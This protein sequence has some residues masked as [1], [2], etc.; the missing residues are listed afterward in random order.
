GVSGPALS[1]R[2]RRRSADGTRRGR[3]AGAASA[4]R[5]RAWGARGTDAAGRV[6]PSRR[7]DIRRCAPAVPA[8]RPNHGRSKMNDQL[9]YVTLRDGERVPALG[10]GT[11]H[12]GEN[13]RH[14]AE[15]AAALRLGIDLGMT[16][17]DT[18]EMYGSGGAEED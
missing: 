6:F 16:L 17:I 14:V 10:L 12:M 3:L 1:Q 7:A 5:Y 13:R 11:W 4:R 18:A 15:E 9:R 8:P 2:P